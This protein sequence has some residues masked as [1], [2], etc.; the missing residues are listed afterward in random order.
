MAVI[1]IIMDDRGQSLFKGY[2]E[3]ESLDK[4]VLRI[5][6][7]LLTDYYTE[8]MDKAKGKGYAKMLFGD[9]H[10]CPKAAVEG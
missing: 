2:K 3:G 10:I 8:L 7:K 1:K 4:K 6:D 9:G 5:A